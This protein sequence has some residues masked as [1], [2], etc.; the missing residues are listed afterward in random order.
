MKKIVLISL[1]LYPVLTFGQTHTIDKKNMTMSGIP[2]VPDISINTFYNTF[3]TCDISWSVIKDSVPPEWGYSFCFP[4]CY[5]EGVTSGQSTF[6]PNENIYLNCHIYPNGKAGEGIIQMEIITNNTHTDTVT[7]HG[8][9]SNISNLNELI[10]T[11]QSKISK[12]YDINGRKVD[13]FNRH[14]IYII[15]YYDL[16][17]KT[18]FKTQ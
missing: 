4:V 13:S 16:S 6:N 8:I 10:Q 3:D 11:D 9:I 12:I 17:R 7:W 2:S 18:I 1:F 14:G 15:E 5:L